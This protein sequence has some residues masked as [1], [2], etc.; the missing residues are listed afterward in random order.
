MTSAPQTFPSRGAFLAIAAFGMLSAMAARAQPPEAA[1]EPA[2]RY[3]LGLS[4]AFAP[5]HD[6]ASRHEFKLR[7]VLAF[8]L[9]RVRIAS[10][11]GNALL[12]FGREAA[13][14][15][16][17]AEL[18]DSDG[19][20][21]G[22]SLRMDN[23]RDSDDA[24]GT[25]GLPD[26]KRTLRGRLYVNYSLSKDWQLDGWL[27]QDLL[28]RRGGWLAGADV[29]WRLHRSERMEWTANL[30]LSVA[31]GLNM[32]SHF[33]V[34]L[35]A[36]ERSGKP[37]YDPGMG[38]RD[39]FVSVGMRRAVGRHWFVFGGASARRLLGPAADSPLVLKPDSVQLSVG[40]A[41]R[42]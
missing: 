8:R 3:V 34:P 37:A 23:G 9:G 36:V 27:S 39:T 33:G 14:A 5:E 6:G 30:G 22:V 10:S 21:V 1:A 24:Q 2:P 40:L 32:R 19:W 26:V 15:G 18:I 16:A 28:G 42:R 11:G 17:S 20:Q 29:G 38:L 7:P 25:R 31:S 13:G 4:A 12:G 41:W 35:S